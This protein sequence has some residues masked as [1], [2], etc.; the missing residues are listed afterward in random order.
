MYGHLQYK[1]IGTG[2][3]CIPG[4]A[5]SSIEQVFSHFWSWCIVGWYGIFLRDLKPEPKHQLI[6]NSPVNN[7]VFRFTAHFTVFIIIPSKKK[8]PISLFPHVLGVRMG[9]INWLN[10]SRFKGLSRSIGEV[11]FSRILSIW[12]I[13]ERILHRNQNGEF[14]RVFRH[15]SW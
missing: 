1:I 3:R 12:A 6:E 10:L 7:L 5:L 13:I 11:H 14:C 4:L 15:V 9:Q 8:S 2:Y